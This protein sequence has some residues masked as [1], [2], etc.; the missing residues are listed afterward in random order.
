MKTDIGISIHVPREGHD[1]VISFKH[2]LKRLFQSTYPAR[3]TT[4]ARRVGRLAQAD[5]NPR[6][7]RGARHNRGRSSRSH[8]I[9]QST[10]PARGTT[11]HQ[12][13]HQQQ[14]H[15]I[16][17]HVPREGHD[18]ILN[19]LEWCTKFQSTCPARGTTSLSSIAVRGNDISIHVPREGHDCRLRQYHFS[20]AAISIHVPREGHDCIPTSTV[21]ATK[22]FQ[23]TCPARGTTILCVSV[24]RRHYISIHVPREGHDQSTHF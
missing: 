14:A 20:S 6:A 24:L 1:A 17:I 10:C 9:F 3:G 19:A 4:A 15:A 12:G 18:A 22:S 5:F 23:S 16:S 8:N 7:P 2:S 21:R 13:L 11:I